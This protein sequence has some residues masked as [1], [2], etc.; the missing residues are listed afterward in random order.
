[1]HSLCA[2]LYKYARGTKNEAILD[3]LAGTI[4]D[5]GVGFVEIPVLLA[6][7]RVRVAF[8]GE[9]AIVVKAALGVAGDERTDD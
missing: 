2:A 6:G 7:K 5:A 9:H 3:H 4:I 1:M 8:T